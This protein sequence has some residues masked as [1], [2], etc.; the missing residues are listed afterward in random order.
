MISAT[1]LSRRFYGWGCVAAVAALLGCAGDDGVDVDLSGPDYPT[2][3]GRVY[4]LNQV[5][6]RTADDVPVSAWFGRVSGAGAHPTVILVHEVGTA[7]GS[8]E[9]LLS[10]VFE[11]LLTTGYNALAIDLRGHGGTPLPADGRPQNVLLV[12]DL[13]DMHL[14]VRA[15][16][17]W[18]RTQPTAD[19]ARVAV[20][21][22]GI[23]G[24]IAYVSTGAFPDDVDAAVALSPGFWNQDFQPLVIGEGIVPF[25]P[26]SVLY[27]VGA[28][29][30]G[31]LNQTAL[32]YAGFA[33]ALASLTTNPQLRVFDGVSNHGLDLLESPEVLPLILDWLRV[34]L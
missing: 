17:G 3:P 26:H 22:N 15:A 23:G 16:I 11:D 6:F 32:S 18:L 31:F 29:D 12:S 33:T 2:G 10:G 34:H 20:M 5:S 24:N 8:Q 28:D 9:W 30:F 25:A 19:P 4:A 14:E 13:E 7:T 1:R 27:L 21:G